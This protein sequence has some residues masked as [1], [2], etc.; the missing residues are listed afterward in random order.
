MQIPILS[1]VFT[2]GSADFRTSYPVNLRPVPKQQGLS[3]GYL[4]PAEGIEE[5]AT[6]SGVCRGSVN[7]QNKAYFV[8]GENLVRVE[9]DG[10]VI[11]IE[12]IGNDGKPVAFAFSFDRL[13]IASN[14]K[15]FFLKDD[16]VSE[17]T[18]SDIGTVNDVVYLD[19]Y[20]VTTDGEFLITTEIS[21]PTSV[22]PL[23][24]GSSE[25]DP[26]PV[27]GIIINRNE[28]YAI[29]RHTIEVF[30]NV[31]G[32]FFPFARI[33]GAHIQ[34]GAVG[35]DAVCVFN[36]TLAFVGSGRGEAPAVY[37]GENAQ[38][39]KISTR[40]IDQVLSAYTEEEIAATFI[41]TRTE[42]GHKFLYIHLPDR[43]LVYDSA[44]TIEL[45]EPVWFTLTSSITGFEQY[46]ARH[47]LWIYN[48]WLCG[49]P[50]LSKIGC[51]TD[52][53]SE[54]Y[55]DTV[56]W[57]FG[58]TMAFADTGGAI[59]YELELVAL[60][61]RVAVGKNPMISASYTHD[62]LTWSQDRFSRVGMLGDRLK[63][64]TWMQ[65]GAFSRWRAYRFQGT[66]D[67]FVSFARLEAKTETMIR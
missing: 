18:D 31:G 37:M 34:K 9:S 11:Q 41:E 67:A 5:F 45:Q 63:R 4:R 56:R 8:C 55:G 12:N 46:R 6:T 50:V 64:I 10:T 39:V 2:D 52:K 21:D 24:Y 59:V 20:F 47:F 29:N 22:N 53:S 49:D 27:V 19:G 25:I 38:T 61:G 54:H 48:K 28:L 17:V 26:D 14:G 44:A 60:T 36:D 32:D 13:G 33:T 65:Q 3:A 62:G 7:W 42:K 57:E 35:R 43:T 40:E 58:T 15:L 66:S 51:L 30:T 23:K 16:V 1:G